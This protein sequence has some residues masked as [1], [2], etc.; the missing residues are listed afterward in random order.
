[1][2]EIPE[3]CAPYRRTRSFTRETIP[4]GLLREHSTAA[5]VWGKLNVERG[6]LRYRVGG[7]EHTLTPRRPG[8]IAPQQLHDV[9]PLTDDVV[10]HVEFYRRPDAGG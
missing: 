9:A 5:G 4:A 6:A 8:V 3:D 10:F 7:R 2:Q 1:M